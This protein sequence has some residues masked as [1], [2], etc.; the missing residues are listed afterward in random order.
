M[1]EQLLKA[2]A[3]LKK[4]WGLFA[5]VVGAVF[6]AVVFQK[7]ENTFADEREKINQIHLDELKK[8][9]EIRLLEQAKNEES[10]R[11]LEATL[12]SVQAQYEDAKKDLDEKKKA[13]IVELVKKH[14]GNPAEL[15]KQ[16]SALTGFVVVLPSQ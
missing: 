8:I 1:K 13:Q 14:G 2:Y 12:L 3:F 9:Q 5:L 15:A 4:Y 11:K 10:Q 7:R 16:L 6:A